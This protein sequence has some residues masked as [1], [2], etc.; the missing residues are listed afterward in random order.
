MSGIV[1]VLALVCVGLLVTAIASNYARTG[2][3]QP[4]QAG[5]LPEL[6]KMIFTPVRDI[7]DHPPN[8]AIE[9]LEAMVGLTSR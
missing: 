4:A 7:P 1:I 3:L 6:T 2:A 5:S 9:D 8:K